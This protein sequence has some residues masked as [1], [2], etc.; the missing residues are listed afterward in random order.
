[1]FFENW[2]EM[3][4]ILISA[5]VAYVAMI[6]ILRVSGKRTLSK[7]NMFDFIVTIAL[8]SLLADVIVTKSNKILEGIFAVSILVGF[9]FIITFASTRWDWF[10]SKINADPTL[11]YYRGE[12]LKDLMKS[13]RVV[14]DEILAAMRTSSIGSVDEVEAIVLE[15]DGSF[16]V[17]Q[18]SQSEGADSA[19]ENV[20]GYERFKDKGK[21]EEQDNDK[22]EN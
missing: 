8:G 2:H 11:L 7:W 13:K 1:M 3:L 6:I 16:S 4:R 12:Y 15:A 10:K 19:L 17:I 5:F 14:R 21:N 22:T 20:E 9:Q 18:K